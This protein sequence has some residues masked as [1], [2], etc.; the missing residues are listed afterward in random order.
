MMYHLSGV[1]LI[2]SSTLK[3]QV[4]EAQIKLSILQEN[5]TGLPIYLLP[6]SSVFL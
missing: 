5:S 2:L 3:N 4:F 1:S 6:L